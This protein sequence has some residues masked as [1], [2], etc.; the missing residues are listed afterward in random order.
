MSTKIKELPEEER[1]RERLIQNGAEVLSNEELLAI[2]IKS[3]TKETSAKEV[4]NKVLTQFDNIQKLGE[5]KYEQLKKIRGIGSCKACTI[6]SAIE[7]GR[8]IHQTI[9]TLDKLKLNQAEII[10][11]HYK[12]TLSRKRQEHFYCIY[13]DNQKKFLKESLLFIGTL[14]FSMVHPRE[15]FKEAYLIEAAGIIC[16]HNHPSGNVMPSREDKNLT[17]RLKE[18][19]LLLGIPILDHIIIGE[20]GYYSFFEQDQL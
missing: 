15:I 6:L 8:R 19:G 11:E 3:G 13:V 1:P 4:A 2:L 10:F 9:P 12:G 16:V 18:I 5:I 7:L 14:N 20:H 17:N